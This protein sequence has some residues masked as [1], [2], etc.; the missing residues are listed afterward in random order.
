MDRFFRKQIL[1]LLLI[2]L[3]ISTL[4]G[5]GGRCCNK[6]CRRPQVMEKTEP[7]VIDYSDLFETCDDFNACNDREPLTQDMFDQYAPIDP[8]H[9][10]AIGDVLDIYVMGENVITNEQ[11]IVA[12]DGKVYYSLSRSGIDAAGLTPRELGS[13]IELKLK[14]LFKDPIVTV[15]PKVSKGL[16]FKIFGRV[17]EP[18]VYPLTGPITL[19]E[20]IGLAGGVYSRANALSN[21]GN[22]QV[23]LDESMED[24]SKSYIVRGN[25][26]LDV[27]FI[28]LLES[29]DN[30]QN[31]YLRPGD[32][33]YI[34][35][36]EDSNVFVLGAVPAPQRIVFVRNM[37]LMEAL[38]DAGVLIYPGPYTP[39]L[40]QILI[41][42]G[43]LERPSAIQVDIMKIVYGEARDLYLRPGDIIYCQDKP[44]RLARELVY[45]AI[46]AFVQSFSTTAANYYSN[47]H[48]F[49]PKQSS[50]GSSQ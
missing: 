24:L 9:R 6:Y 21:A 32:F 25:K 28:S 31:L 2:A 16:S 47:R 8:V 17:R 40:R 34:A 46:D 36:S 29:P 38:A 3:I 35:P 20:A 18:G 41:L 48:W 1:P 43:N 42:R 22:R 27:D 5:C 30:S 19:K 26:K 10:F 11:Y 13:E 14:H 37:T 50:T 7:C 45:I 33:I 23:S 39:N 4:T 49:P 44:Y 12:P 15:V